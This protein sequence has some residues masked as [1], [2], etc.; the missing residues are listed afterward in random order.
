MS[1]ELE[2]ISG[3]HKSDIAPWDSYADEITPEIKDPALKA[4]VDEYAT[5]PYHTRTST[6]ALEE[7]H[8]Q[9]EMSWQL[10]KEYR[11]LNQYEYADEAARLIDPLHSAK[12]ISKLRAMGLNCW[13]Y[14]EPIN[15]L[16]A[17]YAQRRP[18]L[19]PEFVTAVQYGFMPAYSVM[20]FDDHGIP[21]NEKYRGYWTVLLR[22]VFQGF[23]TED[24]VVR[25]FG[26]PRGPAG[27]RTRMLL[28]NFRN[29]C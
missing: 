5:R 19:D 16:V 8:R 22:L 25:A 23:A 26:Q 27:E 12:F 11:W 3:T 15:G 2:T 20:R 17:L 18:G 29:K 24:E 28:F 21:T 10:S 9:K 13:Y 7:E 4:A 14:G 6:Q 1:N